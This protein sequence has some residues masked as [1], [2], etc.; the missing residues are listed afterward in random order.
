[1]HGALLHLEP[2][3][4]FQKDQRR[5]TSEWRPPIQKWS[6]EWERASFSAPET[7]KENRERNLIRIASSFFWEAP[8]IT[9][10][11]VAVTIDSPTVDKADWPTSTSA[12]SLNSSSF[13]RHEKKHDRNSSRCYSAMCNTG[14]YA[15]PLVYGVCG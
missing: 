12:G 10:V 1:M 6:L 11:W 9:L 13:R 7:H 4:V 14:T 8:S 2:S 15:L 5:C 3:R